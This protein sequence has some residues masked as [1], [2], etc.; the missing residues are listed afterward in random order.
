MFGV[1]FGLHIFCIQ[2]NAVYKRGMYVA[3][4]RQ[5]PQ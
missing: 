5:H 4:Q 3:Q 1:I 2:H